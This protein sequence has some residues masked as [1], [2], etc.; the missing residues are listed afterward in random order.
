MKRVKETVRIEGMSCGHC[1]SAVE[2]ALGNIDGLESCDVGMGVA[3]LEFDAE[4]VDHATI[5]GAI[6][7]AGYRVVGHIAG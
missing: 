3:E 5:D 2:R 6:D 7:E 4:K 1:I